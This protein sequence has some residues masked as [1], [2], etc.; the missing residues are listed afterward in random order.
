[1]LDIRREV[2]A[3]LL[4]AELDKANVLAKNKHYRAAGALAAV[5]LEKHLEQI[6]LRRDLKVTRKTISDLNETLKK[7]EVID[8]PT[9]R[10]IGL[11]NELTQ[12]CLQNKKREPELA[13]IADLINGADK[14]IKTVF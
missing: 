12:I 6:C 8:F 10:I 3:N 1:M 11:L 4:D 13:D 9:Y 14:L 7:N 2:Q 5:V